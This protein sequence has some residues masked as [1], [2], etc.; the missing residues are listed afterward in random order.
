[1]SNVNHVFLTEMANAFAV[2]DRPA[3]QFTAKALTGVS[4]TGRNGLCRSTDTAIRVLLEQ[5]RH[6]V[7]QAM[8]AVQDRLP[9]GINPVQRQ[10]TLD[11]SD[12]YAVCDLLGPKSPIQHEWLRAGIYYQKPNRR[13]GLHSHAAEETYVII[14]GHAIWTAGDTQKPL[15]PG[16]IV[17]HSTYLPHACETGLS[18]V[19]ALWRWNGDIATDSYR[20]HDGQDA[21]ATS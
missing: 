5:S 13:Y 12:I 6:P 1:M 4:W 11:H 19:V 2:E 9:W 18:G 10:V 15:G 3:A 17:H 8:L 7:A 21:F 20:I 16:D 14:A